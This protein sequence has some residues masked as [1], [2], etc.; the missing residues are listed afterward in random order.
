MLDIPPPGPGLN[1]VTEATPRFATSDERI[2]ASRRELLT[3]VV[4]RALPF[5][6]TVAP[7]TKPVPFTIKV[8]PAP[9]G[10]AASGTRG[11]LIKGTGF[12][13]VAIP[14]RANAVKRRAARE[15]T[16]V[17][18]AG[19]AYVLVRVVMNGSS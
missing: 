11:W 2:A 5:Q 8:N 9:P 7:E 4:A 6:I 1:T 14:A 13:A 3:N 19:V 18:L 17:F 16:N 10:L 15:I 12:C